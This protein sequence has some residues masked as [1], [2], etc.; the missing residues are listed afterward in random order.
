[1]INF[2]RKIRK[3]LA[4]DNKPLKYMRYAI[5][6][7]ILVVIGILIALGINNWNE[8][9]KDRKTEVLVLENF[10]KNLDLNISQFNHQ[11]DRI[12]SRNRSG[13]II[14]SVIKNKSNNSD[15]LWK[16]WHGALMNYGNLT[17]SNAGYESLK[18]VGF[19]IIN[20]ESLKEEIVNL[21]EN[22][23]LDLGKVQTWG[24]TIRPD[25]DNFIMEHFTKVLLGEMGLKPRDFDFIVASNYFYGLVDLARGQ[26]SFYG[27]YYKVSLEETQ[28]V[29]QL[30]N[31]ELGKSDVE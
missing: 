23:Y 29:L 17:L 27:R 12:G 5:G 21:Y 6:E 18:N 13:D 19:E 8:E 31:D 25:W 7:I 10:V 30:I 24:N 16:H 20:N 3:Q 14:F 9:R 28:R 26:R 2:F 22:T 11:I 1:M 4:D 15:T